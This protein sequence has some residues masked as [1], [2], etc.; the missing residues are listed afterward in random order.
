MPAESLSRPFAIFTAGLLMT[1]G[2]LAT[3]HC[4]ADEGSSPTT[5]DAEIP[6]EG[7]SPWLAE[8]RA[9]RRAWEEQRRAA[10]EAI[11]AR[12]RRQAPW[13]AAQHEAREKA[14]QRRRDERLE[15]IERDRARFRQQGPWQLASPDPWPLDAAGT[16]AP[17]DV[18]APTYPPAGW[19][20]GWYYRGY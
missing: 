15:R 11:D 20:N 17:L 6:S 13:A 12:R 4:L 7:E 14:F 19:N 9:Q 2:L 18:P 16:P 5:P 8:V 10:K 3:S 1:C